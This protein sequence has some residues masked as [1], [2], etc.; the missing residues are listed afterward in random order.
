M[1]SILRTSFEALAECGRNLFWA[2]GRPLAFDPVGS[3]ADW[4]EL[5]FDRHSVVADPQFVNPAADDYT[6]RPTSPAHKL[7]FQPAGVRP[8]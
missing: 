6:L 7:G 5:G 1:I 8:R 2:V 4:Q 3:L